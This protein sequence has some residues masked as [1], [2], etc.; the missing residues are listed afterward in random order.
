VNKDGLDDFY[1]CGGA[2]QAGVLMMQQKNGSFISIDTAVFNKDALSEDVDAAFFDSNGDGQLDLYVVSGGN[3]YSK[4]NILLADR[5]YLNDGK[6]HFSKSAGALPD[7]YENKS[8]ITVADIDHD[9]DSDIFVG[10]LANALAYGVPQTSFLLIND[11]KA[12]FSPANESVI[13]LSKIGMVTSAS[14]N[15]VNKDGWPDLIVAG[16]WMPLTVFLNNKGRFEEKIVANSTGL[17]QNI[18]VDD[19][20]NDGNPDILSG[21]WGLNNKFS[22]GKDGPLRLYVADFDGNG[23]TDQLLSYTLNGI[24]YPFLAKDEVERQLPLLKK[25]YLLY[26]DYAGV[27]MKDVFYGWVDTIKP[28]IAERL[29]SAVCYGDGK[30]SFSISDLPLNQ[31]LS[32]VFSFQKINKTSAGG[33]LYLSGGNFFGVTPYEGRYDAQALALFDAGPGNNINYIRQPFL[34]AVKGEVRDI[35]WLRMSGGSVLIVARNNEPLLFYKM[36]N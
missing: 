28:L 29:A 21:N 35:K 22:S 23:K 14:F 20:N 15:D 12:H 4:G 33:N 10:T 11:G 36:N 6:G 2:G 13:T 3:E 7:L 26:A 19:V 5:L 8:C 25:H 32:P 27:P 30:G 9:G 17:W 16:E 24:E 31:Q 34:D 18:F 1:A